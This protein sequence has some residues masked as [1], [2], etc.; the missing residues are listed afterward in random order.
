MGLRRRRGRNDLLA[1]A[2]A[3]LNATLFSTARAAVPASAST[4][5]VTADTRDPE[6]ILRE[7]KRSILY[8]KT[9]PASYYGLSLVVNAA[10]AE[11]HDCHGA[12]TEA[13]VRCCF[14]PTG[15]ATQLASRREVRHHLL[16][17]CCRR[18]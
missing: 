4:A 18:C 3:A 12:P 15:T 13:T 5:L 6:A 1:V 10:Y 9:T 2:A 17:H 7:L 16:A 11:R 14:A 8:G